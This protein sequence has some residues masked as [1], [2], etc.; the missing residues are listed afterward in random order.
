MGNHSKQGNPAC[1]ICGNVKFQIP[2]NTVIAQRY[3][4]FAKENMRICTQC[5]FL[6][7]ICEQCKTPLFIINFPLDPCSIVA[8][9]SVCHKINQTLFQWT[10]DQLKLL[11][12]HY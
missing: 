4:F 11:H 10:Q 1:K 12:T 3:P 2:E 5:G 7:Y 6:Y 8:E 9:C